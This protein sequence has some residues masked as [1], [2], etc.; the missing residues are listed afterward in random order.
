DIVQIPSGA[1]FLVRLEG[2]RENREC[3]FKDANATIRRTGTEFQ[4]QL[5]ITRVYDEG[6]EDLEDEEDEVQDEKTFLIGEELKLHRDHVENCVSFVWSG[7][8]DDTETQYEFVCDINTTAHL[9]NT[10]EL[11]LLQCLYER[12]YRRSHFGGTEEEIRALEYKCVPPRPF[13]LDRLR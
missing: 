2:P 10:F 12:K 8:D 9:A 6:E 11:T 1:F 5:V 3:I 4:Y 7:F 13:P